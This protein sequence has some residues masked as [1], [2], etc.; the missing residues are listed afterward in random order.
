MKYFFINDNLVKKIE[1]H[2]EYDS[3]LDAQLYQMVLP[4][5]YFAREPKLDWIWNGTICYP[6]I[7]QVTARQIR[8]GLLTYGLTEATIL[9]ALNTLP[10]P[11]KST[12]LI[13]WEYSNEFFRNN[14]FV[15]M[16]GQML[17]WNEDQLDELWLVAGAL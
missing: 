6:N 16:V 3:I 10:E 12:A 15:P 7:P 14:P 8:R 9:A 13:E 17:G 2:D 11:T 4:L 1:E 5:D